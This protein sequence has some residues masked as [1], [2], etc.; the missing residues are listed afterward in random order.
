MSGDKISI[1]HIIEA[2]REEINK[3]NQ[4]IEQLRE[5]INQ[6]ELDNFVTSKKPSKNKRQYKKMLKVFK[7]KK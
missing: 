3:L 7:K 4:K 1:E 6:I 2:K 5:E